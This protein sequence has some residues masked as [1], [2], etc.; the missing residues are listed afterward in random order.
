MR[1]QKIARFA[2]ATTVAVGSFG[3]QLSTA[4]A[5]PQQPII[6]E[7]DGAS[8]AISFSKPESPALSYSYPGVTSI[9]TFNLEAPNRLVVDIPNAGVTAWSET[10]PT[11]DSPVFQRVRIAAH[12]DKLRIVFD[13]KSDKTVAVQKHESNGVVALSFS[14]SIGAPVQMARKDEIQKADAAPKQVAL[15][16]LASVDETRMIRSQDISDEVRASLS[17]QVAARTMPLP[18]D[19]DSLLGDKPVK[20]TQEQAPATTINTV[21]F[22]R[23]APSDVRAVRLN[24][25]A[26]KNF[27]LAREDSNT[28]A[29]TIPGTSL[30][31]NEVGQPFFPPQD[32]SGFTMVHAQQDGDNVV[33]RIG[34]DDNT[35]VVALPKGS[36]L[37]L[38][39]F[40]GQ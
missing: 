38:R 4:W 35:R 16:D 23:L 14:P 10:I 37:W 21:E 17:K 31:S 32:F 26:K 19:A 24:L 3:I 30:D 7:H 25:S 13:L 15:A 34:V 29:L 20:A 12:P 36:S 18:V 28:F 6:R 5:D 39:A 1:L 22:V 11:N 27:T 2:C 8:L 9:K 40:S 33:V